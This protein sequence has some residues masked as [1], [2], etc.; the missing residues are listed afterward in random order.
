M[1]GRKAYF[2]DLNESKYFSDTLFLTH[3][4][5]YKWIFTLI[6]ACAFL[7]ISKSLKTPAI[8]Y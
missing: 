2:I 4:S 8:K 7:F 1:V 6:T 3:I 5:L